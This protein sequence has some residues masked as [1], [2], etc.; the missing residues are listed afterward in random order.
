ML[1]LVLVSGPVSNQ[2]EDLR[3]YL[4][5]TYLETRLNETWPCESTLAFAALPS[6]VYPLYEIV[7]DLV[8]CPVDL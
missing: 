7:T 1:D 5:A 3:P 2:I 4:L 6:G 8:Y